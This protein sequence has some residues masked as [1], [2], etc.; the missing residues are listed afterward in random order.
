VTEPDRLAIIRTWIPR[1]SDV[2]ITD[3]PVHRNVGDLFILAAATRLFADLGC[4]VVYRA[5][6]RDYRTGAARRA[7]GRDTKIV[8][9]GG[10]KKRDN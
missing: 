6:L 7:I 2:A 8:G 4:R 10:G 5:G 1:G 3:V 9:L